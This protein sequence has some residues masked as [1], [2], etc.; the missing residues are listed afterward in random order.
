[1]QDFVVDRL[2]QDHGN[3]GRV[4]SLMSLQLGF[5]NKEN[6]TGLA[7]LGTAVN[8]LS[9]FPG[10]LHHPLEELMFDSVRRSAPVMGETYGR[11]VREHAELASA[12]VGLSA[13]IGLQ[14]LGHDADLAR[15]QLQGEEYVMA[16]ANHLQFEEAEV[17]P[18]ALEVLN[19]RQWTDIQ[20]RFVFKRDPLFN[21]ERL[22]LYENLYDALMGE[23][24]NLDKAVATE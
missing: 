3:I 16:Y 11:L 10:I 1:M 22:S 21:R 19:K 13:S 14:Q 17:L 18:Q 12:A 6:T 23:S 2:T 20:T 15:L 4:L 24:A 5:L 9:Y 8:Y 7:L